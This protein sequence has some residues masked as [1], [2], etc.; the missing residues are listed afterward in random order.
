MSQRSILP[1]IYRIQY[2][3]CAS[4]VLREIDESY[5]ARLSAVKLESNPHALL[6]QSQL[7]SSTKAGPDFAL[8]YA[9]MNRSIE[10]LPSFSPV[11]IVDLLTLLSRYDFVDSV[12]SSAVQSYLPTVIKTFGNNQYPVLFCSLIRLNIDQSAERLSRDA[13]IPPSPLMECLVGEILPC[14]RDISGQNCLMM[15]HSIVRRGRGRITPEMRILAFAISEHPKMANWSL[16]L[17]IQLVHVLSRVGVENEK[18][19]A[20]LFSLCSQSLA[21]VPGPNLQ[22]LLSIV[23]NHSSKHEKSVWEPILQKVMRQISNP[24]VVRSM[25]LPSI[26]VTLNYLARIPCEVNV[27]V[28]ETL[29]S[30]FLTAGGKQNSTQ[31]ILS[32]QGLD[33]AHLASVLEAAN[34]V[35]P[36]SLHTELFSLAMNLSL[37]EGVHNIKAAPLCQLIL[38]ALSFQGS[39]ISIQDEINACKA[40]NIVA[41]HWSLKTE[42]VKTMDLEST[43]LLLLEGL[44]RHEQYILSTPSAVNRCLEVWKKLNEQKSYQ[45]PQNISAFFAKVSQT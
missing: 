21:K 37:R 25:P 13:P 31:R 36:N 43:C 4:Y 34:K 12:F 9:V 15:L 7:E 19:V 39:L 24:S 8:L 6:K 20:N 44:L 11:D 22:Q 2:R 10:L 42:L 14:L 26:A 33:I 17:T 29:L 3:R 35:L 41:S 40:K 32:D 1:L 5:M 27:C 38:S 30:W 16:P 45:L 28:F 23:Y 18:S